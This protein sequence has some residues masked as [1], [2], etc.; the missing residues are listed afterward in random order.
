MH[1]RRSHR[2]A[3]WR[4]PAQ[5]MGGGRG[6]KAQR[7]IHQMEGSGSKRSRRIAEPA[8]NKTNNAT[9]SSK[10]R[11]A[12]APYIV[13]DWPQL[14]TLAIHILQS[15]GVDSTILVHTTNEDRWRGAKLPRNKYYFSTDLAHVRACARCSGVS[16]ARRSSCPQPP[17]RALPG[18]AAS[19]ASTP[20]PG[21][22][23]VY[24]R[25]CV[26]MLLSRLLYISAC[27]SWVCSSIQLGSKNGHI[28]THTHTSRVFQRARACRNIL[29]GSKNR[30]TKSSSFSTRAVY[31]SELELAEIYGSGQKTGKQNLQ[32]F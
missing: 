21:P 28:H 15:F 22:M 18:H 32:V 14:V 27:S 9:S 12:A 25:V 29:F 4:A 23:C 2:G 26:G 3:N 19:H 17:R 7:T 31:F 30:K 16:A 24:V 10:K 11:I 5:G 13:L 20:G 1:V 6:G 8:R